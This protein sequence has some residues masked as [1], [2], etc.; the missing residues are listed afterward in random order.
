MPSSSVISGFH[1]SARMRL[2][3]ISLRGVPSG[4]VVSNTIWPAKPV[5]RRDGFR[6]TANGN[7][8]AGAAIDVFIFVVIVETENDAARQIV[9]MQEFTQG[10][11]GAPHHDL[12]A[13][14]D[15]RLVEFANQRR[16]HVARR[17]IEIVIGPIKIA[18]HHRNVMTAILLA[19]GLTKFDA[20]DLGDRIPF[21]G[22]LQRPGQQRLLL[23]RLRREFRIDA[24]RAQKHQAVDA[25]GV[26][27]MDDVRFD[28]QD[29][30]K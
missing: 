9:H 16:Q 13:P 14:L 1:P 4:L 26:G 29:C 24:G 5:A 30:R 25:G 12:L 2:E 28:R 6:E 19:V 21:I 15:L 27:R 18:R 10:R 8:R 3:S 22:R 17:Q 11:A 23:D 20:G 7:L